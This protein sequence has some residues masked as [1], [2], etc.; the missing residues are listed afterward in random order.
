MSRYPKI[1]SL[2]PLSNIDMDVLIALRDGAAY[3]YGAMKEIRERAGDQVVTKSASIYRSLDSMSGS[4]LVEK[5]DNLHDG[6]RKNYRITPRG[7][8]ALNR[9]SAW[10]KSKVE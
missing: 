2:I 5:C 9:H 6:R 7:I 8:E 3:G 1:E 4:G 10:M